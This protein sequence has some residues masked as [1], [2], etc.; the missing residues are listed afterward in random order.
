MGTAEHA[1]SQPFP[2]DG[3]PTGFEALLEEEKEAG[4]LNYEVPPIRD[5]CALDLVREA[6]QELMQRQELKPEYERVCAVV[7]RFGY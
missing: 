4:E 3:V 2:I 1:A 7:K 5:V 6:Y